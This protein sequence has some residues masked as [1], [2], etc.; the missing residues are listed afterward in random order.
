MPT[1]LPKR[2]LTGLAALAAGAAL[3]RPA[4]AHP[5]VWVTT[6]AEIAYGEGGRV[7]GIRNAWTFDASYSA[8]V[9]QGL[10]TNGDGVFSPDELSSLAR[11]NTANLA[12]F[13]YFTKLKVAGKE[14][15]FADPTEPRMAMADGKLT[16]TFLLPLK[17]PVAQGRGVTT[18]EVY[19]PTYFVAFGLSDEADAARLTGAPAGCAASL[20]RPKPDAGKTADGRTPD[21][22]TA[23]AKPGLSEAFFEALTASANYGSQ[24]ANRIIVACP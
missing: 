11:E 18:V 17:A 5:H 21:G 3:A 8:F 12:E 14:Q 2:F 4:E 16:L 6:K 10:D 9:V 19:D 15:L 24:F 7:T 1:A 13:G 20:T 23:D 22:K